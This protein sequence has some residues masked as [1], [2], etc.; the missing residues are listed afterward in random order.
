MNGKANVV[1]KK[2]WKL[3]TAIFK[4]QSEGVDVKRVKVQ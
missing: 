1:A 3:L 4:S 2:L